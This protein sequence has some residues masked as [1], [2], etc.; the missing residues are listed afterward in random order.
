[1]LPLLGARNCGWHFHPY[2]IQSSHR[3]Y[4]VGSSS[5]SLLQVKMLS[6]ERLRIYCLS[7][8]FWKMAESVSVT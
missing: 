2:L 1:M 5:T 4:E 7:S 3:S 6:S 8:P